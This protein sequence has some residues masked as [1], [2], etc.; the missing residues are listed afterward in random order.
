ME[1]SPPR[2]EKKEGEMAVVCG[3]E[4]ERRHGALEMGMG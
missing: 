1:A 4:K 3:S 2:R